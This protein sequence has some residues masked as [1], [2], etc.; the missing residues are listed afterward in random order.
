MSLVAWADAVVSA[1]NGD[2]IMSKNNQG[3]AP[4]AS[5]QESD[6]NKFDRLLGDFKKATASSMDLARVLSHMAIEHACKHGNLSYAQKFVDAMPINY[7]RKTAFVEWMKAF[8]PLAVAGSIKTGYILTKDKSPEAIEPNLE[9][10]LKVDFWDFAPEAET[11]NFGQAEVFKAVRATLNKF[12]KVNKD[13]K[14]K[15]HATSDKASLAIMQ[16]SMLLR[17]VEDAVAA[18][19]KLTITETNDNVTSTTVAEPNKVASAA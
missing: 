16:L 19:K 3:P 7:L 15:Y 2:S 18:G 10:A 9:G 11:I 1:D 6:G 5:A 8:Y 13:G 4:A 14:P 12:S 17:H